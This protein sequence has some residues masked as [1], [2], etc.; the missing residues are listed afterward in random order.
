MAAAS[1]PFITGVPVHFFEQQKRPAPSLEQI[2]AALQVPAMPEPRLSIPEKPKKRSFSLNRTVIA[3]ACAVIIP[4]AAAFA[5]I[6]ATSTGA[7]RSSDAQTR[8]SVPANLPIGNMLPDN[9]PGFY[10]GEQVVYYYLAPLAGQETIERRDAKGCMWQVGINDTKMGVG[11]PM[12]GSNG[13]QQ[14]TDPSGAIAP[15]RARMIGN[16]LPQVKGSRI[17]IVDIIDPRTN[18]SRLPAYA[19]QTPP[20]A[21]APAAPAPPIAD[22]PAQ[23]MVPPGM[24]ASE[25][26]APTALARS[27]RPTPS[28]GTPARPAR[29][30]NKVVEA[31]P[32]QMVPMSGAS[33]QLVPITQDQFGQDEMVPLTGEP[34]RLRA[35][36]PG[37][38]MAESRPLAARYRAGNRPSGSPLDPAS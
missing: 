34:T 36:R 30:S 32:D 15:Y 5:T 24:K 9:Y 20:T 26:P 14:C 29:I 13:T 7:D 1:H 18:Q 33:E 21:A 35:I 10:P 2:R 6:P 25:R 31:V 8:M 28:A 23:A 11:Y 19:A 38:P 22:I 4:T 37:E 17:R 16:T 12:I 3:A 27:S